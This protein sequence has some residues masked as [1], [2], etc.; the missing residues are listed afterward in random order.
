MIAKTAVKR[1]KEKKKKH[2]ETVEE[3]VRLCVNDAFL[4]FSSFFF[5]FQRVE[6]LTAFCIS[7]SALSAAS[8]ELIRIVKLSGKPSSS[9]V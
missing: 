2:L 8:F 7:S 6:F 3:C 9:S 4:R 1:E 5:F